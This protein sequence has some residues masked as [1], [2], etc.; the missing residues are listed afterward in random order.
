[1]NRAFRRAF[2][3]NLRQLKNC[4]SIAKLQLTQQCYVQVGDV[5]VSWVSCGSDGYAQVYELTPRCGYVRLIGAKWYEM[6][7]AIESAVRLMARRQRAKG[8]WT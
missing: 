7:A 6:E 5:R 2:L 4:R 1:M 8:V 3:H